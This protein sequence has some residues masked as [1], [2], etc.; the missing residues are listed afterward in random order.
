MKIVIA[1]DS[2]KGSM[3]S[4][5]AGEA[6]RCGVLRAMDA[7][8]IVKPL[9][10]GGEGTTEALVTGLGGSY[11][12]LTAAGPL[13]GSVQARYGIL[14]GGTAVL[15]MAQAAGITL[16]PPAALDPRRAN[17]FGVGEMMLDAL[18]AGCRDFLMGI[19]GSAT[20]EGGIGMLSALGWEFYDAAGR[21]LPPVFASL[22]QVERMEPVRVPAALGECRF[23]IA[24][25]VTNP[26]CGPQ[27]AVAVYGP[28]KGVKREEIAG[29]DA[30][31]GHFASVAQR[32]TGRRCAEAPG[33]GA[34]G[35][36]GFALLSFLPNVR[37]CPGVDMVLQAV[38]LEQALQ[39]AD[40]VLTGEGRLDGQTAMG[41]AP[42]GVARLAKRHGCRVL[43]FAG[44]VTEDAAACHEAGI[45]A[46]FPIV[47]GAATLEK[48]M[49]PE[50]ARR[51]MALAVEQAL[52]LINAIGNQE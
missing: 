41:K 29:M 39:G 43:A 17:T 18:H 23:R 27:G 8:I 20:T 11:R 48:A 14:P 38:G 32:C 44:A 12:T 24:C 34:A 49:E 4:M 9:A 10:D 16:V 37:L 22:G 26:L 1:M 30:A 25:D 50:T 47:R 46:F 28:Q 31:M 15:E 21:P 52:R 19:G 6:A 45:D 40:V 2:F 33:A 51:N 42:V 3:T 13:G 7:E 35:G 36:L 5:E